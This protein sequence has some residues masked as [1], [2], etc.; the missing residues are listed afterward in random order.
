MVAVDRTPRT[1]KLESCRS[2]LLLWHFVHFG[3][4]VLNTIASKRW[5]HSRQRY[6]KIGIICVL[7]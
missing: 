4:C 1:A 3:F 7:G 6:S 5:S 2:S